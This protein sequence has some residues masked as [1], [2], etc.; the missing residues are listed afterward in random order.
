MGVRSRHSPQNVATIV[1]AV[2][3]AD[4]PALV[5]VNGAWNRSALVKQEQFF[6]ADGT[7]IDFGMLR[8]GDGQTTANP[9]GALGSPLSGA[10]EL[11]GNARARYEWKLREYAAF[12]QIGAMHLSHSFAS[13]D[14][15]AVD[16]PRNS[17]AYDLAPFTTYAAS[18]G[19]QFESREVTPRVPGSVPVAARYSTRAL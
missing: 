17:T 12:M 16:L 19:L 13:T 1:S 11:Q 8:T 2:L 3:N 9:S 7:P 18:L 4:I 15:L 6:W 10:P 14:R 5:E